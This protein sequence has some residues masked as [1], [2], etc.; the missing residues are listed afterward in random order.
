MINK[1]H[2]N[3]TPGSR[4]ADA[5]PAISLMRR[6]YVRKMKRV[7]FG[8]WISLAN[9]EG[10][11]RKVP[12]FREDSSGETIVVTR[13]SKRLATAQWW[14]AMRDKAAWHGAA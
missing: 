13:A 2:P 9:F 14:H 3:G 8:H 7:S 12:A 10:G 11:I 6:D 5:P 1:R 4:D